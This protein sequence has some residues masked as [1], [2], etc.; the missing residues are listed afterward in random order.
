[1]INTI[2]KINNAIITDPKGF[3]KSVETEYHS[4]IE[5]VAQRCVDGNIKIIMLAGPSGSG[6]TTT[7]HI[8]R[9]Y[10]RDKG[11]YCEVVSL[12]DFY[13]DKSKMPLDSNGK[14]DFESVYS[15]N[16]P[17]FKNC[18]LNLQTKGEAYLPIY[19]FK[20]GSKPKAK[21]LDIKDG[22][23]V[24][25]E[26]LHALNPIMLEN[27]DTSLVLKIYI[28][29]NTPLLYD[30]NSVALTSR[31]MRLIRRTCRDALYRGSDISR[32][33]ELWTGVTEGER[34][35]LYAFKDTAD[36]KI[37]TFHSFEPAVFKNNI[38]NMLKTLNPN[39][40]NYDY[41][42]KS[43]DVLEQI[44]PLPFELLPQDSLIREF[45]PGGKY[46]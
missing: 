21:Y 14:P 41:I 26:G 42:I 17:E 30:D 2:S 46:E 7:A 6:K 3:I 32:T 11:H 40:E 5:Q 1:M 9:D 29:V 28:S 35:Y 10:I 22:G 23:I 39:C 27:T 24:I 34:K 4:Q 25:V 18:L 38:L 45:V 31:L 13:L 43:R 33:L 37:S 16:L 20:T 8:L 12:D 19:D 36:V 44:E 15:L